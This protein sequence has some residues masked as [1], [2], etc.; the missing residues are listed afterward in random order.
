MIRFVCPK[1]KQVQQAADEAAGTVIACASCGQRLKAPGAPKEPTPPKDEAVDIGHWA[2]PSPPKPRRQDR[3][4]DVSPRRQSSTGTP[5]WLT[6]LVAGIGGGLG[7]GMG[8]CS[9]FIG[10]F[11]MYQSGQGVSDAYAVG[12]MSGG[13]VLG[14]ALGALAG[15]GLMSLI[16]RGTS[17]RPPPPPNPWGEDH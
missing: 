3:D 16:G 7:F 9:G 13:G 14:M 12:M 6:I 17:S 4:A 5:V 10:Q 2:V 15:F 11:M 8:C 1:C